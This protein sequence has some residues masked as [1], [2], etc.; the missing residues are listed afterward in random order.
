MEPDFA[1]VNTEYLSLLRKGSFNRF[2]YRA[3]QT[4]ITVVY[5]SVRKF[6]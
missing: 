3:A 5:C 2:D 1:C 6:R 4:K